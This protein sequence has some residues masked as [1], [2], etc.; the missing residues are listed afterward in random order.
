MEAGNQRLGI[1][2]VAHQTGHVAQEDEPT[3]VDSHGQLCGSHIGVD[4]VRMTVLAQ[5]HGT[6]NR[7]HL[8]V[9]GLAD[10]VHD[11]IGD[12]PDITEIHAIG[13]KLSALEDVLA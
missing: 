6:D 13:K 5:A 3:R 2:R 1:A 12:F 8:R 4:I 11:D 7:H 10:L 9:Q